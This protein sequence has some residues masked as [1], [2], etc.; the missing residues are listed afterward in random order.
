M[1]LT[2]CADCGS[3]RTAATTDYVSCMD[4]AAQTEL[5]GTLRRASIVTPENTAGGGHVTGADSGVTTAANHQRFG[6]TIAQ[7]SQSVPSAGVH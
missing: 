1:A 4:C 3:A 6:L 7:D 2:K 5:D